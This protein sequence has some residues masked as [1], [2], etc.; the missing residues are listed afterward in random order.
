MTGERPHYRCTLCPA[1]SLP[2]RHMEPTRWR[3]VTLYV[4][5]TEYA[6]SDVELADDIEDA[7]DGRTQAV[8]WS[9]EVTS[10]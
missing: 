10:C 4:D 2:C 1:G 9:V 7:V 6:G 3:M 8:A 5:V